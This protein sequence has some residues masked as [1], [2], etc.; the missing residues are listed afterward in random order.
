M[1]STVADLGYPML[2]IRYRNDAQAPA[3]NGYAQ[4]GADEWRDLEGAVQY[5]LDNGAERV[6]LAGSS[7]GG[8]VSLAFL[9][10]SDLAD[11]VVGAFLDAPLTDFAQVVELGAAD[12]G[13]PGPVAALAMR[14]AQWRF[15]FDFEAADYTA[16]AGGFRTPMLIVQGTADT[17]VAPEVSAAFAAAAPPGL[18]T[19]ELFE[20]AGHLLS[21]NVD[22]TRYEA[23]LGGFLGE[24]RPPPITPRTPQL[25]D[26]N[27]LSC[28]KSRIGAPFVRF[29]LDV[30]E[31]HP[32]NTSNGDARRSG[33][34]GSS[35]GR[36]GAGAPV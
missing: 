4:F 1:A 23:L 22:R 17:T 9:Q 5:A 6:V 35:R 16:D 27:G 19:L 20:G 36:D 11:R 26:R 25:G 31:S 28:R 12:R 24:R 3:G 29:S 7:M 32:C 15:G 34:G 21:W 2:L 33:R 18:V 30:G 13:I 14:V 10:N 8:S